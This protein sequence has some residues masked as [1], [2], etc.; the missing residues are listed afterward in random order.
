MADPPRPFDLA[1]RYVKLDADDRGREVE[2]DADFWP[3]IDRRPEY[4][5]GRLAMVFEFTRDWPTWEIH[6]AG[7]ELVCVLEGAMR[8]V[9]R[10]PTGDQA[11]DVRAGDSVLVPRATWHTATQI[12]HCRALFVTPCEG[13]RNATVPD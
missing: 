10:L 4:S 13:T 7:E 6:P 9:L 3:Q 11:L 12:S 1:N 2:V 8:L 5:Q